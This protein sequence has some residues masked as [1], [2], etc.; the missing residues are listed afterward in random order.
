MEATNEVSKTSWMTI[1]GVQTPVNYQVLKVVREGTPERLSE[2]DLGI[3][4][5]VA[6][7]DVVNNTV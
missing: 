6:Y 1:R 2:E 7:S 4:F 3:V 5:F